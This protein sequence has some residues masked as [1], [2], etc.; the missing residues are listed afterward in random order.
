MDQESAIQSAKQSAQQSDAKKEAY[1]PIQITQGLEVRV[2]YHDLYKQGVVLGPYNDPDNSIPTQVDQGEGPLW[3]VTLRTETDTIPKVIVA[4]KAD[5]VPED[6]FPL[7]M[8]NVEKYEEFCEQTDVPGID[9]YEVVITKDKLEGKSKSEKFPVLIHYASVNML[10]NCLKLEENQQAFKSIK[11]AIAFRWA[12]YPAWQNS[13]LNF[14]EYLLNTI[15]ICK[16]HHWDDI[17]KK[18]H[19]EYEDAIKR[20]LGELTPYHKFKGHELRAIHYDLEKRL[21]DQFQEA[22][23]SF[24]CDSTKLFQSF[25]KLLGNCLV[26]FAQHPFDDPVLRNIFAQLSTKCESIHTI[27]DYSQD[28][29]TILSNAFENRKK[30][31]RAKQQAIIKNKPIPSPHKAKPHNKKTKIVLPYNLEIDKKGYET[32]DESD[33]IDE[34]S[35]L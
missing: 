4:P 35:T 28:V 15:S 27:I 34:D 29:Q 16:P 9:K 8:I 18:F 12:A 1:V 13:I 25:G 3:L 14:N 10:L 20:Q 21:V 23:E 2:F 22:V 24:T 6:E 31:I 32:D 30:E 33:C 7:P 17:A 26:H 11:K 19:D 5:I